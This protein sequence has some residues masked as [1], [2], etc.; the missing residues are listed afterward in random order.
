MAEVLREA[1]SAARWE[2]S[3]G[4]LDGS[5]ETNFFETSSTERDFN[6]GVGKR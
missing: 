5:D 4:I 2:G 3:S 1:G 6:S